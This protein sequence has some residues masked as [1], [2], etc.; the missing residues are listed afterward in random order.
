MREANAVSAE[1]NRDI[2]KLL[3]CQVT[4][5]HPNMKSTPVRI[6]I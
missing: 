1:Q 3:Q 6:T 5:A 4:P 2:A